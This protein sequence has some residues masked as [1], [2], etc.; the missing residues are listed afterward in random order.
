MSE[1]RNSYN[2]QRFIHDEL[3]RRASEAIKGIYNAWRD[4]GRVDPFIAGWPS[5]KILDDNRIIIDGICM[6]VLPENRT[7][8]AREL[9]EFASYIKAYALLLIE[10]RD[11]SIVAILES[12]H[13]TRSWTIPI[14]R[15]GDREVLGTPKVEDDIKHIGLLWDHESVYN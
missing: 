1:K 4:D 7:T 6:K 9:R 2:P 10:Q 11:S 3:V 13:G 12:Q 14:H 5:E 15:S 8:W